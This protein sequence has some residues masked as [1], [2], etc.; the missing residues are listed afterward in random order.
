MSELTN[1][2][3]RFIYMYIKTKKR[4]KVLHNG[5]LGDM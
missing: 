5:Y 2:F 3:L 4:L 1:E